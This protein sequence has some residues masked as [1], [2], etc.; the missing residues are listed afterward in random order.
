MKSIKQSN[1][2]NTR[3][4]R[5]NGNMLRAAFADN[6]GGALVEMAMVM[7]IF[8]LL[9][10]G[11]A[12]FG[13]MEYFS[14]EV[15]NAARAGVAYAAQSTATA[16]SSNNAA[17]ETAAQNDAQNL[18]SITTLTVTPSTVCQCDNAG[19]FTNMATCASACA[20]P[21]NV[22]TYAQVNTSA[23]VSTLLAIH[24]LPSSYTLQGQAIMR[25]K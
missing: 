17:I 6:L 20:S 10:V 23:T 7:P 13:R 5:G 19:T 25:I 24:G 3:A 8:A 1:S 18:T 14:I 11:V 4:S 15:S 16:A 9:L 12:E 21:G 22:I 2:P